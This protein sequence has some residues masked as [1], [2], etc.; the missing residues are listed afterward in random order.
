MLPT[1]KTEKRGVQREALKCRGMSCLG[2]GIS[3]CSIMY[4]NCVLRHVHHPFKSNQRCCGL[5]LWRLGGK[6]MQ[7]FGAVL[8]SLIFLTHKGFFTNGKNTERKLTSG[9]K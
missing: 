5:L 2:F 7:D 9:V 1:G 4:I 6:V 3:K 8:R